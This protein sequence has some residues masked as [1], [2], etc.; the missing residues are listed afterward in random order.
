L[1]SRIVDIRQHD[2]DQF[3]R[4]LEAEA[5]AWRE[6]L[7]WDFTASARLITTCLRE[8]RLSGSALIV[9]H[10]VRG[11]C[12]A[13]CDGEKGFI[14]DLFVDRGSVDLA[15]ARKLLDR[16]IDDLIMTPSLRR[17]EAQLPHFTLEQ[18]EPSFHARCFKGFGRRFMAVP[19]SDRT[20]RGRPFGLRAEG[21]RQNGQPALADFLLE[22]WD[23]K[24]DRK[25]AE[26]LCCVYRNHVDTVINDQYG[27]VEGTCRLIENIV[28][29]RG[30]GDYLPQAS[31]VALHRSTQELA[32]VLALTAVGPQNAHIPQIAI[33]G[34]FQ[35]FGLGTAM[36]ETSFQELASKNFREVSLTVTDLNAGAVRLYERL[37]F[38]TYRT[39]G[40]FAWSHA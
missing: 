27:S 25:A 22:P 39:F 33:A 29:H 12:F 7:R 6:E 9:D 21:K 38:D 20:S 8:K 1:N 35:G 32:G 14:G 10:A 17:I 26:L 15:Q 36:L 23:R 24:Y 5:R 19:L 4:L 30:C 40:A 2:A 31:V 34:Q 3:A 11:Y 18:L 37:G 28:H 13:F 16:V